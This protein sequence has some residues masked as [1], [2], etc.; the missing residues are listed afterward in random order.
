MKGQDI[1]VRLNKKKRNFVPVIIFLVIAVV[2]VIYMRFFNGHLIY[3]SSGLK[4]SQVCKVDNVVTDTMQA[5]ILISD[6]KTEY[7]D[8]FGDDVWNKTFDGISF[9]EYVKDKVRSKLIRVRC[10]N[11]MAKDKGVALSREQKEKI[12]QAVD[13]FMAKVDDTQ[14]KNY[15]ITRDKVAVMFTEFATA[16]TLYDDVTSTLNCEVSADDARVIKIQYICTDSQDDIKSAMTELNSGESFYV[17]SKKYN[18]TDTNEYELKRGE[19]NQD[20][21]T[22]AFN[23]KSGETSDIVR[24]GEQYYIIKCT[25]DNQKAKTESNKA[26]L[27]SQKQLEGFNQTFESYEASKYVEFNDS[28]WKHKKVAKEQNLSVSFEEIF[29]QY[30][31]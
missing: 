23:L 21:E 27:L 15:G 25:S 11:L 14:K 18:T 4:N 9:D 10:M 22:I 31:K 6:M 8:L 28:M 17:V 13:D 24:V 2:C 3:L 12:N 30:F 29:N 19:M 1:K 20:F 16:Q 5:D 7:E 26:S